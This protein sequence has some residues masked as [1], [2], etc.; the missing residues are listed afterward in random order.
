MRDLRLHVHGMDCAE[1]TALIRHALAG[2]PGIV[3]LDFDLIN[4]FVHVRFDESK[5]SA[6]AIGAAI[7]RTGLDAHEVTTSPTRDRS[8]D[9]H[10]HHH[11][12]G[13]YSAT[14]T[15]VSGVF[16]A[17]AWL[18]EGV[19]AD[20]WTDMF[21][22]ESRDPFALT[23]YSIAA[24]TGL[25]PT[26]PRAFA[27]M[28][29]LRL[30][31]H[32]LVTLSVVGA[33]A[34]SHWSEAA[35]VAFLFGLAHRMEAWS[36][37][38]ARG[39]IAL[40]SERDVPHALQGPHENAEV[41][42]WIERFAA[43]YTPVVTGIAV[44]VALIPPV[45]MGGDWGVWFYRALV[46]LVLGCPC[47][48]V[49]STPV[50]VV[51]ALSSAARRGVLIRGGAALE[52]AAVAPQETID[53]GDV[54]FAPPNTPAIGFLSAH[55]RRALRVIRQNV[56]IALLTKV[57]FLAAAP[58]GAAPLWLAV[59]ADTGATVIVTLNALRLLRAMS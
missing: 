40:L 56:A 55:A 41:E 48:L 5:T 18:L 46:F 37:E 3:G 24:V 36:I 23:C 47:A 33:F 4:A 15:T 52:R 32:V 44:A 53:R 51:A 26:L 21:K 57:A 25:W 16:F 59:M 31:M 42:R 34:T 30:D 49:I 6:D 35:A 22:D 1:E 50:T 45:L 58:F 29:L 20:H 13:D 27:S 17:I 10:D 19:R 43:I 9:A 54:V 8:L 11:P 2:R 14:W 38:R 7:R 28:R 39:E 12:H